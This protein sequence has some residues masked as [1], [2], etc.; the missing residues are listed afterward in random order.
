MDDRLLSVVLLSMDDVATVPTAVE[1]VWPEDS[2]EPVG[3]LVDAGA[4][5]VLDGTLEVETEEDD[6]TDELDKMPEDKN[7]EE[8]SGVLVPIHEQADDIA[9]GELLQFETYAGSPVVAVLMVVVYVAQNPAANEED[10]I[11]W[12]RQLLRLHFRG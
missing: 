4:G 2:D 9:D 1:E 6:A 8:L 3:A 11:S 12:R 10:P 7:D 5:D